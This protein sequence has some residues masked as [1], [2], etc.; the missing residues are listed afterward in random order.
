MKARSW[1]LISAGL[2]FA[3]SPHSSG[4]SLE[5][6][7]QKE[8]VST[9]SGQNAVQT[10]PGRAA[11][12]IKASGVI[13]PRVGAE[14]RVGSRLSGVVTHLHVQVGDAVT[15]G[16]P[17][18]RLDDRELVARRGEAQATL[19]RSL[20]E[21]RLAQSVLSRQRSLYASH[22]I[23]PRD[24]EAA[25]CALA[26]SRHQVAAARAALALAD[27]QITYTQITAPIA[28]V[29][30]SVTTQKGETVSAGF[31]APTFVTL[32]DLSRLEVW[33]YVDETDIGWVNPGQPALF[34]VDTYS[35]CT[36][37][38]VITAIYPKAEIRDNVVNYIAVV[39]FA[40]PRDRIL[41]PEM[42]ATVRITRDGAGRMGGENF[43]EPKHD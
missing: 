24:L 6:G 40:L 37:E 17:L 26:V 14:V 12:V 4:A 25:E 9:P 21:A 27:T 32:I 42:T 13:K 5:G 20:A 35:D 2:L 43:G 41:R 10:A 38:G 31:S 7:S 34:T 36:F 3:A 15:A 8:G 23:A 33:A 19:R 1:L 30:A 28:G 39:Q 18:A 11:S 29:V 22:S 16:Q